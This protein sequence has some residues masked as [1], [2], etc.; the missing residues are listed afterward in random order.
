M[1]A[2]SVALTTGMFVDWMKEPLQSIAESHAIGHRS[3]LQVGDLIYAK[4]SVVCSLCVCKICHYA[5]VFLHG[6]SCTFCPIVQM[7]NQQYI[8]YSYLAGQELGTCRDQAF[9]LSQFN[10]KQ[11]QVWRSVSVYNCVCLELPVLKLEIQHE[12]LKIQA[13]C[14][15][16]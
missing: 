15:K 14:R 13:S 9:K 8:L 11:K 4:V 7:N 12:N 6:A 10:L 1:F 3:A 2:S 5:E 16:V